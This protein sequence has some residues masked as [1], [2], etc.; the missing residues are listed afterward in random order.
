MATLTMS[1]IPRQPFA[2][3]DSSRLR[4]LMKTKVNLQNRQ[5][6][7]LARS[8]VYPSQQ[9][10]S[11][12]ATQALQCPSKAN[13]W[14]KWTRRTSIPRP[15]NS[16]PSENAT[17]MKMSRSRNPPNQSSPLARLSPP[18]SNRPPLAPPSL[19]MLHQLPN[20][21]RSLFIPP[22]ANRLADLHSSNRANYHPPAAPPSRNNASN[23]EPRKVS[24]VRSP[25]Q[26]PCQMPNPSRNPA[27]RHLHH[28]G[29]SISTKTPNKMK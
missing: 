17:R 9:H 24:V 4:T 12:C 11:N 16:P 21:L 13:Q 8:H 22:S 1:A 27:Q 10:S 20:L 14:P 15:S 23:P 5:N 25:S 29:S 6:G 19:S 3:L 26:P 7:M 18:S 2:S 28:H